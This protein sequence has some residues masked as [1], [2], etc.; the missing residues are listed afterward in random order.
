MRKARFDHGHERQ[1]PS[2]MASWGGGAT[3]GKGSEDCPQRK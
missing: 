2:F 3:A 1:E